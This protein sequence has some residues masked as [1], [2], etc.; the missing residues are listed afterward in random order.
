MC[1]AATRPGFPPVA[2]PVVLEIKFNLTMPSWVVRLIQEFNLVRT[3]VPKY[4]LTVDAARRCGR[5]R[6]RFR[7]TRGRLVT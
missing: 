1:L 4:V 3:S 6:G 7:H 5:R 2:N